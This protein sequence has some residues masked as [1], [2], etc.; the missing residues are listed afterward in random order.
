MGLSSPPMIRSLFIFIGSLLAASVAL[1]TTYVR[2]EKDGTKTYSDRPLPGGHEVE[3]QPAQTYSAP[4]TAPAPDSSRPRE[5]QALI[6]AAN[7]RYECA[8]APRADQTFQNP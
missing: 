4:Q 8:L 3:I 1:G 7:F 6:E 5:E 2:V